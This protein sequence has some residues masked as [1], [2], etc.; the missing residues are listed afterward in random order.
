MRT[1]SIA[2]LAL[3]D[4]PEFDVPLGEVPEVFRDYFR[5]G[6]EDARAQKAEHEAMVASVL[7]QGILTPIT[8][9]TAEG[10]IL[11]GHHRF[12]AAV[13]AGLSEMPV[14]DV[15]DTSRT[16][17]TSGTFY[18]LTDEVDFRLDP[19]HRPQNNTTL[20]GD[21]SVPGIFVSP[22]P[23]RWLN[24]YGYWRPWVV[25]IEVPP[26]LEGVWDGGYGDETFIPATAFDRIRVTRVLPLDGYCREEYGDY[27]WTETHFGRTF[28]TDEPIPAK[29]WDKPYPKPP[30]GYRS[31]DARQMDPA[32][33]ARY[34][35]R[36]AE[37]AK[38]RPG[39]YV[40]S[41]TA[42]LSDS[43]LQGLSD[44][45]RRALDEGTGEGIRAILDAH[46]DGEPA[47][48]ADVF[49]IDVSSEQV[50]RS[51]QEIRDL[52][53]ARLD[54]AHPSGTIEVWRAG[55]ITDGVVSVT[56]R[57]GGIPTF[58]PA[59][60]YTIAKDDV[61]A[62]TD[63]IRGTFAEDE[64][65]V[66]SRGLRIATTASVDEA[67]T[68][69]TGVM[70]ALV[71]PKDVA[72]ALM[73]AAQDWSEQ[74]N[75]HLTV[76]YLGTTE[77]ISEIGAS[78][79][80][81][82]TAVTNFARSASA[83]TCT[84]EGWGHFDNPDQDP[85][86]HVLWAAPDC[87]GLIEWRDDLLAHLAD[88]GLAPQ[89]AQATNG[90]VPHITIAY[91][92]SSFSDITDGLLV[93]EGTF[94]F[95]D[96][97]L[98]Y[99]GEYESYDLR[100][101]GPFPV[102][103]AH[104]PRLPLPGLTIE[105]DTNAHGADVSA[106]IEGRLVG[107]LETYVDPG[108]VFISSVW[109][110]DEHQRK[111]IATAM[112]AALV[113]HY[114]GYL[115]SAGGPEGNS[116]MGNAWLERMGIPSHLGSKTANGQ[117]LYRGMNISTFADGASQDLVLAYNHGRWGVIARLVQDALLDGRV[118]FHWTH[119]LAEAESFAGGVMLH[120]VGSTASIPVILEAEHDPEAVEDDTATLYQ[121]QTRAAE[122]EVPLKR[123]AEVDIRAVHIGVPHDI[124][125]E[126]IEG[127][128]VRWER[129]P[130]SL[131]AKTASRPQPGGVLYRGLSGMPEEIRSLPAS[132]MVQTLSDQG[133]LRRHWT[134]DWA[135]AADYA[136]GEG[137]V[138]EIVGWQAE[139]VETDEGVL[140]EHEVFR[141]HE[142]PEV[143]LREGV[144]VTVVAIHRITPEGRSVDHL[145]HLTVT[146]A[147]T[148]PHCGHEAQGHYRDDVKGRYW[149]PRGCPECGCTADPYGDQRLRDVAALTTNWEEAL[150]GVRSIY[151]G[152]GV[153]VTPEQHAVLFD[154]GDSQEAARLALD[155][156]SQ[157]GLGTHW[158]AH[159]GEAAGF[160]GM[161][162]DRGWARILLTAWPPLP[163]DVFSGDEAQGLGIQGYHPVLGEQEIPIR[164]GTTLLIRR[165][166]WAPGG[167]RPFLRTED[168]GGWQ[169]YDTTTTRI[170][171]LHEEPEPALPRTE[172][173]EED[174][175]DEFD[176]MMAEADPVEIQREA[177]GLTFEVVPGSQHKGT[178]ETLA[179]E[180][181]RGGTYLG[182][183]RFDPSQSLFEEI[184]V[185]PVHRRQGI[186]RALI[187]E[188]QR[189]AATSP[190][191][192]EYGSPYPE[193]WTRTSL[194]D[195]GRTLTE[196]LGTDVAPGM[197]WTAQVTTK[198]AAMLY[199]PDHNPLAR[200]A[201]LV[202]DDEALFESEPIQVRAADIPLS[203]FNFD[204]PGSLST[205][206]YHASHAP[207]YTRVIP[208]S[209][210]NPC[211]RCGG[212]DPATPLDTVLDSW[213]RPGEM[214]SAWEERNRKASLQT[215][216]EFGFTD[217]DRGLGTLYDEGYGDQASDG[218]PDEALME[219]LEGDDLTE[220]QVGVDHALAIEGS[221]EETAQS[222]LADLRSDLASSDLDP[223]DPDDRALWR[224]QVA[225]SLAQ[226]RVDAIREY[227]TAAGATD[228]PNDRSGA[229]RALADAI[230]GYTKQG[231]A[232]SPQEP[233]TAS[234]QAEA[235]IEALRPAW[236]DPG[237]A[238]SAST[239]APSD[240]A[241]IAAA[242]KAHLAKT[243]LKAFSPAEQAAII[244]EGENVT[245]AN[246]DRLDLTGTHYIGLEEA[247]TEAEEEDDALWML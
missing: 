93:P 35:Q 162:A 195:D 233:R 190:D 210:G 145:P 50:A 246:L 44:L 193:D 132:E 33:R 209:P 131:R 241:E 165:V 240:N 207:S 71:P 109:V 120:W 143:T 146:A 232:E 84:I 6:T 103:A 92:D 188:L 65:L 72:D 52:T 113:E 118:G 137:V 197:G 54:A 163:E 186:A 22:S 128:P 167:P 38:T 123:G 34:T 17:A 164:P 26:G 23:E 70:V 46:Y 4:S 168:G 102:E 111:G 27:G 176:R 114:P 231:A 88:L 153:R 205:G 91:G 198:D 130:L 20:G 78:L 133:W 124:H 11:D 87:P 148:C 97:V 149:R 194:T 126:S 135:T 140:T 170:A 116:P 112:L 57:P 219:G 223:S 185:E 228:V 202:T 172:G 56:T 238:G 155:L 19:Q 191:D 21:W 41:R 42:A 208:P 236:L 9:D 121:Y 12:I 230:Q 117:P 229:A 125:S 244:N 76:A 10:V 62:D 98:A 189:L 1:M 179:I 80:D 152:Y 218:H 147:A 94:E 82:R 32:W 67:I 180:A 39:A 14:V 142:E 141:Y 243:A 64:L 129:V 225:R 215:Q 2:D 144:P 107:L 220:Y 181:W 99:G 77:E 221:A 60:Q 115:Y 61:L 247:L 95:T 159:R 15:A 36:V 5:R 49:D 227:A 178:E 217:P 81:L 86:E 110:D 8:V 96:V 59:T 234:V 13:A 7:A 90:Y 85:P 45:T 235:P 201:R 106:K 206:V 58:G 79:Q 83:L 89:G 24:G 239:S 245:A 161:A 122:M 184:E 157:R 196:G 28:D 75:V 151:R 66:D 51:V 134:P 203:Q 171:V 214:R 48:A 150:L 158:S 101:G 53:R 212:E 182:Y 175:E 226:A 216:A 204:S 31:P 174:D 69:P 25:E 213:H 222:V 100:G 16:A 74:G 242:A 156:V 169:G 154:G 192:W 18:H 55:P 47:Y 166:E 139:D 138:V 199:E 40:G 68:T 211:E 173:D 224:Q 104:Q 187:G 136:G 160:A 43:I 29:E 183:L 237:A 73:E 30:A 105:V 119:D 108:M 177:S 127:E 200:H 3:L 63:L 37:F